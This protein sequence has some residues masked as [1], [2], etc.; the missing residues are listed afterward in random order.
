VGQ[1]VGGSGAGDVDGGDG[2][3]AAREDPVLHVLDV[4]PGLAQQFQHPGQHA[5]LVEVTHGE[6]GAAQTARCQVDAVARLAGGEHVEARAD[7]AGIERR[8]QRGLVDD[9][10][11]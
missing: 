9:V 8:E 7:V 5:D 10:T 3:L 1:Q 6:G 4:E 11:A 2:R